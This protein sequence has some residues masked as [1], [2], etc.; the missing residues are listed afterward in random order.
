MSPTQH[1]IL[2]YGVPIVIA[3][4]LFAWYRSRHTTPA[5]ATASTSSGDTPVGLGQLADFENSVGAEIA[6]LGG[7]ITALQSSGVTQAAPLPQP[8]A[9]APAPTP[10]AAPAPAPAAAPAPPPTTTYTVQSGNTLWGIAAHFYGNGVD[11]PTIYNANKGVI[12]SNPNLIYRGQV[13]TI[14]KL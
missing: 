1:K 5:P 9:P 7:E 4:G 6:Q 2:L 10:A 3:L 11:W 13:L 14:P 12:G 8:A